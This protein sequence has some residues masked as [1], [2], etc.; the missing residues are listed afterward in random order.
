MAQSGAGVPAC[1]IQ[2]M[3]GGKW[4]RIAQVENRLES[5]LK[6]PDVAVML[7]RSGVACWIKA[8]HRQELERMLGTTIRTLR[9]EERDK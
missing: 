3:D 7:L 5:V 8:I 9:P 1:M 2:P 4:C 6:A